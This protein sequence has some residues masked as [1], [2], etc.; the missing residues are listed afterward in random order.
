MAFLPV[1]YYDGPL[2]GEGGGVDEAMSVYGFKFLT[3]VP[4]GSDAHVFTHSVG[5]EEKTRELQEL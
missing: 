5:R 2:K 1:C 4:L 3:M